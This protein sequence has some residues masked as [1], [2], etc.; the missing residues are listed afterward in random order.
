[1]GVERKTYNQK[2]QHVHIGAEKR[3]LDL[4]GD[5]MNSA[6]KSA[7]IVMSTPTSGIMNAVRSMSSNGM[8]QDYTTTI[9]SSLTGGVMGAFS[10]LGMA[11]TQANAANGFMNTYNFSTQNPSVITNSLSATSK[12]DQYKDQM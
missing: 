5:F 12:I 9:P 4:L 1:M 3:N 8:Q 7:E 6:S 2:L 11:A 10:V